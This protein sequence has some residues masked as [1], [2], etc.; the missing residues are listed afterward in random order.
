[1]PM[2]IASGLTTR[3]EVDARIEGMRRVNDDESILV[4][5]PRLWQ[6]WV[7]KA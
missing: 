2:I 4:T 7:R 1:M 6:V 5:L 3:E